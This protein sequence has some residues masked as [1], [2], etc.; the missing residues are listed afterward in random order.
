[1]GKKLNQQNKN[2]GIPIA[3]ASGPVGL[4]IADGL[5]VLHGLAFE[6]AAGFGGSGDDGGLWYIPN[7]RSIFC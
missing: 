6:K 2:L 5:S 7:E 3:F 4:Q 1:M